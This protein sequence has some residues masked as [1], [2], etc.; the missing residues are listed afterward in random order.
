[1]TALPD[2]F[3][4]DP[5]PAKGAPILEVAALW[6]DWLLDVRHLALNG[7]LAIGD[8]GL[9]GP[10][11]DML[12]DQGELVL[13][14]G[15]SASYFSA[16]T[17]QPWTGSEL[18]QGERY[19]VRTAGFGWLIRIV[20]PGT[21]L[22]VART[23]KREWGLLAA[24]GV[25][26]FLAM[27]LWI[28]AITSPPPPETTVEALRDHFVEVL[29]R[30]P[31]PE[32]QVIQVTKPKEPKETVEGAM[33]KR[34]EGKRG[35]QDGRLKQA[36]EQRRNDRQVAEDAGFLGFLNETGALSD[37]LSATGLPQG[38]I[39]A[40]GRS[41]RVKGV[42]FGTGMGWNS[43]GP[44][45]GGA[46]EGAPGGTG[47]K[48]RGGDGSS[49]VGGGPTGT[50]LPGNIDKGGR[51][52]RVGGMDA[53]LI[54]EVVKQHLNQFRYC[55][56]RQLQRNPSLGGKVTLKWIIASDGSVSSAS[57]KRDTMG[58]AAVS[59]C[60]T[61]VARRMVF[62]HPKGGIVI[63]SYPFLFSPG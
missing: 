49:L 25:N 62:P 6:G 58:N 55:Y 23:E 28:F 60:M 16:G 45:G 56:Q 46:V 31:E 13:P 15:C 5:A 14:R 57:V 61:K 17:W 39:D 54:D 18:C 44:G 26:A 63:V 7:S 8:G 52:I 29:L 2:W 42:T 27:L 35:R 48:G 10:F 3:L 9:P 50:K 43:D 36:M 12:L 1:M 38:L 53:A 34:R 40:P 21:L 59:S 41:R 33:A 19:V 4:R 20:P 51:V 37:V 30:Q 11:D 24:L 47:T 32:K 22:P